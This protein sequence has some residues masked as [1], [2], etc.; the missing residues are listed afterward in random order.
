MA[1][2]T[3]DREWEA[4]HSIAGA[5]RSGALN[6]RR[7]AVS[8]F[9]SLWSI[10]HKFAHL[11]R[12][13]AVELRRLLGRPEWTKKPGHGAFYWNEERADLHRLGYLDPDRLMECLHLDKSQVEQAIVTGYALPA[14]ETGNQPL[15][16]T[17]HSL[18]YCPRCLEKGFHSPLHQLVWI[19]RC[20][21][22]DVPLVDRCPGCGEFIPYLLVPKVL[23]NPYG[24]KCGHVLWPGRDAVHWPIPLNESEERLLAEYARWRTEIRRQ[25]ALTFR[26][27]G[28]SANTWYDSA[29][30][31]M[32]NTKSRSTAGR[33]HA[34]YPVHTWPADVFLRNKHEIHNHIAGGERFLRI[35]CRPPVVRYSSPM[36]EHS[37][38]EVLMDDLRAVFRGV[39]HRLLHRVLRNHRRC[40][41]T[42][43]RLLSV[44]GLRLMP[45]YCPWGYAYMLWWE[46]WEGRYA[47]TAEIFH[48]SPSP[49]A[50]NT[51][52]TM[53]IGDC[54]HE[55]MAI[56]QADEEEQRANQERIAMVRWIC[57]RVLG[58][59]MLASF[60][61][62][63]R[64][65]MEKNG[66]TQPKAEEY[67]ALHPYFLF[68]FDESTGKYGIHWWM[69]PVLQRL[70]QQARALTG[71]APGIERNT[72]ELKAKYWRRR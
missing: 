70:E 31:Q 33:W 9:E 64:Y 14:F 50:V 52:L 39:K 72:K 5:I 43:H 34:V 68:Q 55:A 46:Q 65:T 69:V 62:T 29:D 71:H 56:V 2:R 59:S 44:E 6:W 30:G 22:H 21:I 63:V 36:V 61:D 48:Q 37:H 16:A 7:H 42:L 23:A 54:V 51:S 38:R 60:D 24:C 4:T 12:V 19:A 11:N 53:Q 58:L 28:F 8:Q 57:Q 26:E 66:I 27:F 10:G 25:S 45:P 18:R 67:N 15:L 20:P 32:C 47:R 41:T 13:G 3:D 35:R 40:I 17:W 1:E 49:T